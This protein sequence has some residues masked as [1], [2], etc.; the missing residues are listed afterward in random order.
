MAKAKDAAA[1]G[2]DKMTQYSPQDAVDLGEMAGLVNRVFYDV[3]RDHDVERRIIE[4]K[5]VADRMKRQ[6]CTGNPLV[7]LVSADHATELGQ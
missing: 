6:V 2:Y 5:P 4:G 3:V 1:R 7:G